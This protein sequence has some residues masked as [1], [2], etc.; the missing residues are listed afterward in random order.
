MKVIKLEDYENAVIESVNTLKNKG[1]LIFPTETAYGVGV[2][3]TDSVAVTKLLNYKKRPEGKPI[4]I[5]VIDKNMAEDYVELNT[6]ASNL[7]KNFLPGALTVVSNSKH[8]TD[9]R[10]ESEKQTLGVRIPNY[11]F[12]LDVI[13]KFGKPITTT[14]ANSAGKKTPYMISDILENISKKQKS[15]IDL[16]IDAGELP[17]NPPSTVIDT[18]TEELT[19]YRSGRIDPVKTKDIKTYISKS[20]EETISIGE[21]I[22]RDFETK[23]LNKPLLILLNGELGA[24]K[25]H[26]TKGIAKA[27]KIEKVIKSPTYNYVNEYKLDGRKLYHLDAWKL[28]TKTDLEKLKFYSWFSNSNIIVIEWPSVIMNIDETYFSNLSYLYIDFVIK[29]ED[30]R[31]IRLYQI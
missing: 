16:I 12:I 22:I 29:G 19:I 8:K 14:S 1:I 15:L 24:G 27:L 11:K 13:S 4:S 2:D 7:Y 20:V 6:V 9:I 3:A 25:T 18:T 5:G 17:H 26:L 28:Q 31:K 30:K 23:Y 10:L 21:D